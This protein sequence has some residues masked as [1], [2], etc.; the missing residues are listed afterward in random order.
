MRESPGIF[1]AFSGTASENPSSIAISFK[2]NDRYTR[3]TFDQV[4][5]RSVK[6]GNALWGL[7]VRNGDSI[8]IMMK[9]GPEWPVA[10]FAAQYLGAVAVLI[11]ANFSPDAAKR[12]I[13]HSRPKIVITSQLVCEQLSAAFISEENINEF[14]SPA[15]DDLSTLF[16]TSGT[17][18][19]PKAV[20]LS[21]KNIVS[22]ARSI[23][24]IESAGWLRKDDV[25]ISILPLHHTYGF[26]V[27][28][29]LPLLHG[30]GI[31][32]PAMLTSRDIAECLRE[33][34]VSALA[35]VPQIFMRIHKD[36]R[37]GIE[38]LPLLIRS[39]LKAALEVCWAVRKRSRI[40]PARWLLKSAH[41]KFGSRLR[42]IIL[43]GAKLDSA[44]VADFFKWG[45]TVLE[46]YGLTETS[47]IVSMN[48]PDSYRIGSVGKAIPGVKIKIVNPGETGEGEIAV[49]G[50]NVMLGYYGLPR[51]T[52]RAIKGGWFS[53]GDLGSID[54]DGFIFVKGR[55]D[56]MLILTSGEN[57]N[58]EEVEKYY[59]VSP[60]VKE[61]CVFMS[62]GTGY[63]KEAD[64]LAAVVVPDLEYLRSIGGS[65]NPE[66]KIKSEFDTL[67]A[68]LRDH[69]RIKGFVLRDEDLPKTALGKL[70]RNS[71][72]RDYGG[73]LSAHGSHEDE[74]PAPAADDLDSLPVCRDA[75]A[76]LSKALG[77]EVK[78]SDHIEL[79]L[80]VDSLGRMELLLEL[81]DAFKI[82]IADTELE[83]FYLS[84]TI[85]EL[86]VKAR[87]Y[88]KK[89]RTMSS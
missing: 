13:E 88:L 87:P 80:G 8:A 58:P 78:L 31:S 45:F 9:N 48:I 24:S 72:K 68:G 76:R 11:D 86:F 27:T 19:A 64:K 38:S 33:T 35:G 73:I 66:E 29:I 50:P 1:Q 57:I 56:D 39:I 65:E 40:N 83:D 84:S 28:C 77:R 62:R 22:N 5:R 70:M 42:Y 49:K 20:A 85:R 60:Y 55:K 59:T 25:F 7:G 47:P 16:Y 51:Q 69:M 43:G 4:Y 53:T 41:K 3:L 74:N 17:T 81:Q 26:M 44:I 15:P 32:Y 61:I 36:I 30:A 23:A 71:V 46:G 52:T 79:D 14:T 18:D 67:S 6:L 63:F 37:A 10:F 89:R 82:E 54:K 21:H 34:G 12:L 2:E 75:L